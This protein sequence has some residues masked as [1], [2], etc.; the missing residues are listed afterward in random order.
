M[1]K[2]TATSFLRAEKYILSNGRELEKALF[3]FHFKGDHGLGIIKALEA[4]QNEDG[5]FGHGIEPDFWLKESSAMATSIA[6]SH[7]MLV[8]HHSE[9]KDMIMK[10]VEY[11][12]K[13]FDGKRFGW[14]AVPKEVNDYPHAPWWEFDKEEGQTVIDNSW[15]NP[16]VELIG[17]LLRYKKYVKTLNVH[18]LMEFAIKHYQNESKIES[19]HEVYCYIRFYNQ[20]DKA[21]KKDLKPKLVEAIADLINPEVDQWTSYVPMPLN[22]IDLNS[23]ELF[24]ISLQDINKNL[25]Y[26]IDEI[27]ENG[28]LKP[29]WSWNQY[30]DEWIVSKAHWTG[31]LTLS[32]LLKLKRFNRLSE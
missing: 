2:L 17:Y 20:L 9:A 7:L 24:D 11:L 3:S 8:D 15:G 14:Y 25:D 19:E 6:L 21:H 5:G 10:A 12:E 32:V 1:K 18:E 26:F 23:D 4:Y 31:V 16:S 22:F 28:A 30:P 29:V 13:T 27:D